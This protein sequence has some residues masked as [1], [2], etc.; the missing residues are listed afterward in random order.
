MLRVVPIFLREK[1]W[2]LYSHDLK[3]RSSVARRE[4]LICIFVRQIP[5]L[6]V[7]IQRI[8]RPVPFVF[9]ERSVKPGDAR[10]IRIVQ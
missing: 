10:V 8:D 4:L 2:I 7:V 9:Q 5:V 6:V 3:P 1:P